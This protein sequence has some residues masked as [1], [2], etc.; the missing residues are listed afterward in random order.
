LSTSARRSLATAARLPAYANYRLSPPAGHRRFCPLRGGRAKVE[1]QRR[2]PRERSPRATGPQR[3]RTL[4]A[5]KDL[6]ARGGATCI[7]RYIGTT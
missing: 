2:M 7:R 5:A 6:T 4:T 3:Q 1:G